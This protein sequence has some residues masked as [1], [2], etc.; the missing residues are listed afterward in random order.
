VSDDVNYR[1]DQRATELDMRDVTLDQRVPPA[2][3]YSHK[4]ASRP[5]PHTPHSPT[6]SYSY[7]M[8]LARAL[9]HN[10][11]GQSDT[12]PEVATH[13]QENYV[14]ERSDSRLPADV[15]GETSTRYISLF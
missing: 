14:R 3:D 5:L 10:Y 11:A 12:S 13:A 2:A 4:Y 1:R 7:N 8:S 15:T 6:S 9:D